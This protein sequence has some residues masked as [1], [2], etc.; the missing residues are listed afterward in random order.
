[1]K[2]NFTVRNFKGYAMCCTILFNIE[3]LIKYDILFIF[4]H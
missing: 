1:M 4:V 3:I 2:K